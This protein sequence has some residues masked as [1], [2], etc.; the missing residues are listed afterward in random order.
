MKHILFL[1]S[2]LCMYTFCQSQQLMAQARP[3]EIVMMPHD[4]E[5]VENIIK[6]L[7]TDQKLETGLLVIKAGKLFLETPYV[8]NTLE[9]GG[10]EKMVINLRELD[11]TT[12]AENC[13]AL[14]RT[15]QK[16]QPTFDIFVDELRFIR[17]RDGLL[18]EYPSRLHYF[19]DWI[20]NNDMK[21]TIKSVSNEIANNE[22]S[23]KV[24]FMSTHP[25]AY[26]ALKSYPEYV[27]EIALQENEITNRK[28]WYI[29]KNKFSEYEHLL[30]DGDILGITTNM[31]GMDI[32]H[33]VI[34][35]RIEGRIHL[36]HASLKHK[37]VLVST[38]TL[39]QYLNTYKSTTGIMVARPL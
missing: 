19:S 34:A 9:V 4:K 3:D 17:Y 30:K 28:A 11:C 29:P 24:S 27:K 25:E 20:F 13:L 22:F 39:E 37:K 32:S 12:F 2:V 33:V 35:I 38:E 16:E 26:P 18:N 1:V 6:Q 23:M 8:A 14:A 15:I 36:I 5:I 10:N 21:K 31:A 7:K